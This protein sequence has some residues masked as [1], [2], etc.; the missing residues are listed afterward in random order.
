[1][2]NILLATAAVLSIGVP[3]VAH[4]TVFVF[5]MMPDGLTVSTCSIEQGSLADERAIALNHAKMTPGETVATKF[6]DRDA[7][8]VHDA[9]KA[10]ALIVRIEMDGKVGVLRFTNSAADCQGTRRTFLNKGFTP[11]EDN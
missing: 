9:S 2:R 6:I 1:M 4:A 8:E 7:Q 10:R 3:A 5:K 11:A